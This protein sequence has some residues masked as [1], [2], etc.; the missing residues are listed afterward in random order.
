MIKTQK[1]EIFTQ[2][3]QHG[4]CC[5]TRVPVLLLWLGIFLARSGGLP[6]R[7]VLQHTGARVDASVASKILIFR[8]S[9]GTRLCSDFGRF[10]DGA[11][12]SESK[13]NWRASVIRRVAWRSEVRLAKFRLLRI[14]P[15]L[16]RMK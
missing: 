3:S 5:S 1:N 15:I 4:P 14:D 16:V 13:E 7:A 8:T 6:T 12:C 11:S 2:A 10:V 9:F